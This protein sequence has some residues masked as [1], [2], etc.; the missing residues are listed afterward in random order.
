[1]HYILHTDFPP[2]DAIFTLEEP[3]E[4][5]SISGII[6]DGEPHLHGIVSRA[7]EGAHGG[8]IEPGCE[9]AY[10]AEIMIHKY[11]DLHLERHPEPQSKIKLLGPKA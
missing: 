10:L 11:P 8:H 9:V 6:A 1:M 7:D 2:Q 3:L 4:L 5:L